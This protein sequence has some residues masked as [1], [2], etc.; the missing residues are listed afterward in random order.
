MKNMVPENLKNGAGKFA[1]TLLLLMGCAVMAVPQGAEAADHIVHRGKHGLVVL[2]C[3]AKSGH[4]QY[5]RF[6]AYRP[7]SRRVRLETGLFVTENPPP[8]IAWGQVSVLR[9]VRQFNQRGR[10]FIHYRG[11]F[12]RAVSG[13]QK[14]I[15]H[16]QY[17]WGTV[18]ARRVP[19][20]WVH[21]SMRGF[22]V[23]NLPKC[24]R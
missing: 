4:G 17:R 9:R 20:P 19:Y 2:A 3:R 8:F 12:P 11:A 15:P 1:A 18:P 5:V 23:R 10:A 14:M 21:A 22:T 6:D 13:D 24:G 7:V 16:I